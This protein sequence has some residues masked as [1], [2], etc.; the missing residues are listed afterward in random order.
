LSPFFFLLPTKRFFSS[1]FLSMLKL[2]NS[3]SFC[4]FGAVYFLFFSYFKRFERGFP[5][6]LS[7]FK[8]SIAST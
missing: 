5:L 8:W 4:G 2:L 1:S 6:L 7:S 3:V